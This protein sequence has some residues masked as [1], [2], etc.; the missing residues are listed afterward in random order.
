M[1]IVAHPDDESLGMGGVLA[2]Y[3]EEG[4]ATHVLTATRGQRGRF[5]DNSNRPDDDAVGQVREQELRCAVRELGVRELTLL[6]Y[7]DGDLDRAEPRAAIAAIAAQLR[8]VRPQ[9]VLTFDQFGAYG[10]PDHIAISQF[11]TAATMTAADPQFADPAGLAPH[12]VS[13]LYY[14]VHDQAKWDAYQAA[15]KTL[16]SRV[17]GV[18]RGA[19]AWPDWSITTRVDTRAQWPTVWRAVQCHRTQNAIYGKLA[20]LSD[21]DHQALWGS[22]AYYRVFSRVNGGRE[23]E[24]D[25]FT[26][27]RGV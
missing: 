20:T 17:D 10:H 8:R 23:P 25:F 9:V 16:I 21:T 1:A 11:A 12:A 2:R 24:T 13:K 19:A 15:F 18:E 7:R 26:G 6:D 22:Q 4:V 5:F 14:M 27:L 3:A